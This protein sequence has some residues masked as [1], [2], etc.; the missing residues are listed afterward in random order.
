MEEA[1]K[2]ENRRLHQ[3]CREKDVAMKELIAAID[4]FWASPLSEES[5]LELKQAQVRAAEYIG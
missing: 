1:V 4:K 3:V 2:R 5:I